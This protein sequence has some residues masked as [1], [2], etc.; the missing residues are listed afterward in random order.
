M[1]RTT[2]IISIMALVFLFV[3]IGAI[4]A[5]ASK[6]RRFIAQVEDVEWD[7]NYNGEATIVR[8]CMLGNPF[9]FTKGETIQF[10]SKFMCL[11][12]R[13]GN[14]LLIAATHYK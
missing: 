1:K 10:H 7:S 3:S 11:P 5:S 4:T 14:Y 12:L 2:K 9:F 13:Y 8:G 6:Y